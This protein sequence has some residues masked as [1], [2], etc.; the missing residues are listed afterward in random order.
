MRTNVRSKRYWTEYGKVKTTCRECD[1]P[2]DAR[3][4]RTLSAYTDEP[5][6]QVVQESRETLCL[7]CSRRL[8]R[9]VSA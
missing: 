5:T 8:L 7:K 3:V 2:F 9:E 6:G 4:T 1:N